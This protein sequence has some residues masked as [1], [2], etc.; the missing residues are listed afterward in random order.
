[1]KALRSLALLAGVASTAVMIG[2]HAGAQDT[3]SGVRVRVIDQSGTAV[4]NVSVEITHVP[5]GRKRTI[6][7]NSS[8]LLFARGLPVGGPY[9]VRLA[10]GTAYAAQTINDLFL[11][12]GQTEAVD[13]IIASSPE[14]I[15]E[16]TVTA[17]RVTQQ[18]RL[19]SSE[20]FTEGDIYEVAA[21]SRDF[22]SALETDP[23]ILLD[24]T[25]D[26]GPGIQIAGSN[27][28]FNSLTV[29]GVAQNDNFG[30]N[31]GGFP[32]KRS[33]ISPDAIGQVDVNIAP[34]SVTFGQF[35]GGNINIVTKSGTNEFHGAAFGFY[36]DD[37]LTGDNSGDQP[38]NIGDFEE[39]VYGASLGG[40]I[41]KDKLFF[42]ASYERFDSER[43]F[44]IGI[45]E[46][47][48]VTQ[49]DI[50]RVRQVTQDVYGFDPLG[51][52]EPIEEDDEKWLVKLDWNINEDHRFAA[53]Y[54]RAESNIL[55]DDFTNI[56]TNTAALQSNRY[57][58]NDRLQTFSFQLFSDWTDNFSTEIRLGLKD[59][60]SDQSSFF[61]DAPAFTVATEGGGTIRLGPDQFRHSNDLDNN[62]QFF[63]IKGDWYLGNHTLTFGYEQEAIDIQNLFVPWSRG[64]FSFNSIDDFENRNAGFAIYGNSLTGDPLD[65]AANFNFATH[66]FYIQDEWTP[67]PELTI[68]AGIRFD[69]LE[70]NDLPELNQAFTERNGFTNQENLDGKNL[71]LPRLG[72]N[73]TPTDRLTFRGGIGLFGGGTPNVW[74]SNSYS[75]TGVLSSTQF[76]FFAPEQLAAVQAVLADNPNADTAR[77]NLQQFLSAPPPTADTNA[78]DPDFDLFSTWKY[79]LAA[80]YTADLSFIGLGDGWD[81]SVEGI[82]SEV[83]DAID[84]VET[85]RTQIDTAP[86]GR[87][88]YDLTSGFD[89]ILTN[90]GQGDSQVYTVT[91]D[92]DWETDVGRFALSLGYTHQNITEVNSGNRFTAFEGFDFDATIDRNNRELG[93]SRFEIPHRFTVNFTWEEELFGD[94]TTRLNLFWTGRSGRNFSY[95]FGSTTA[96]GGA[97]LTDFGNEGVNPG[98][99]L[100]YIPTGLNDP[101]INAAGS[102]GLEALDAFIDGEDCLNEFRG[103]IAERASCRTP[104]V[105][106]VNMRLS[107]EVNLFNGHAVELILDIENLGNLID[108]SWGRAESFLAPANVPLVNVG[109]TDDGSQYVYDFNGI[110]QPTINDRASAYRIQF[111]LRYRF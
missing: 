6:T 77:E 39:T 85:R 25:I 111:G 13:L 55:L 53:T 71:F 95:T 46:I 22:R 3:T 70:N 63:R 12:L 91:V 98:G 97:F 58:F 45:D 41:V 15:E 35:L 48:G 84:Y 43:S 56:V 74:L 67:T 29:D 88:I 96:F 42:F 110:A 11:Q 38:L 79:S 14:Q 4:A 10:D 32:T 73:W 100:A 7:T 51:F 81:I 99:L 65:A 5:T 9:I 31:S 76:G 87:P 2:T 21:I 69:I 30:L 26:R 92:K 102:S 104:W 18:L 89:L 107:Q 66:S 47:P 64:E 106:R 52:D 20:T 24:N 61:G 78:I 34:Y 101:L 44:P 68:T 93:T 57:D 23:K 16:V 60:N 19:G 28:R 72:F 54:Q 103:Q 36:T 49:Q 80:D 59:V 82:F 90:T 109:L 86:D 33:P 50:N 62:T 17:S 40:P 108:S 1:M 94:N 105:N 37:S 75:N 27:F 83:Q 8:G